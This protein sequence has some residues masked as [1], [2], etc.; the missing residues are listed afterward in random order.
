MQPDVALGD[1][2]LHLGAALD[3]DPSARIDGLASLESAGPSQVAF[4]ANPKYAAGLAASRAGAV[5]V[6]PASRA[7][8]AARGAALVVDDP[9]AAYARLSQWWA[10][11]VRPAAPAGVHPTAVVDPAARLGAGVSVGPG[12]VVEADAVL[13]DGVVVG[14]LAFVG[15]GASVGAGSRLDAR[16]SVLHGSVLGARVAIG[17]GAVV[18]GDGFGFAPTRDGGYEKIEQLGRAVLEDDVDIGCNTTVDRGALGDTRI[19]RGTKIDNLVQVAH[20]VTVGEHTVIAG[21]TG[22][23]GSTHVGA[24]CRIGGGVGIAGHIRIADGTTLLGAT[25]VTRTIAKPGVYGGPF[26]FD[27]NASWEKN[28]ATLRKLHLL[29]QRVVALEKLEKAIPSTNPGPE[30]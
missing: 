29:R 21:C 2:A 20:N 19:G 5:L 24:R 17:A 15:R 25:Q 28:A 4:L 13:G 22:I 3:G 11:R 8:A 14:A 23:A 26:P 18:G 1:I 16:A 9:Y 7:A 10:A 30:S 12:A 6:A 27:D